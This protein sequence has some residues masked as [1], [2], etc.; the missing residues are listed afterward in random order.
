LY[1]HILIYSCACLPIHSDY[2]ILINLILIYSCTRKLIQTHTHIHTLTYLLTHL[3]I[4]LLSFS[5]THHIFPH[6]FTYSLTYSL[7]NLILHVCLYCMY[8]CM[9]VCMYDVQPRNSNY[10]IITDVG[11]DNDSESPTPISQSV[12]H[13]QSPLRVSPAMLSP[14]TAANRI[15]VSIYTCECMYVCMY[16]CI[17]VY[18]FVCVCVCVCVCDCVCVYV[19]MCLYEFSST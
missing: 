5:V 16:V 12:N 14:R 2:H 19:C 7:T 10:P 13:Q 15:L 9:Y 18:M 4:H 11:A 3:L 6:L 17:F 1:T 8:V